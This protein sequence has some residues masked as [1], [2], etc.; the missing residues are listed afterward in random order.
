MFLNDFRIVDHP[1]D[2]GI[3]V[4]AET[5]ERLFEICAKGMFS[6]ICK[7]EDV[8]PDVRKNIRIMEKYKADAEEMLVGWLNRLLYIHEVEKMLFSSFHIK[9]LGNKEPDIK[10]HGRGSVKAGSFLLAEA[11]GQKIDFKKHELFLSVK[12]PTYHMLEVKKEEKRGFWKARVI[13]DV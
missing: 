12:A 10:D 1:S 13:F 2:T 8:R 4:R 3:I 11:Y 9:E 7:I 5:V 6:I